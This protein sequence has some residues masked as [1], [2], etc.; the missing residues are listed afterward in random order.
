MILEPGTQGQEGHQKYS[1]VKSTMEKIQTELGV[2]DYAHDTWKVE[3]DQKVEA[4]FHCSV[5]W[6]SSE[7]T[8]EP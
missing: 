1:L 8:C 5:N 7:A 6:K 3:Q 2:V 4:S